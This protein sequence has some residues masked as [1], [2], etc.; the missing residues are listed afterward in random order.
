VRLVGGIHSSSTRCLQRPSRLPSAS[1]LPWCQPPPLPQARQ[2]RL[3]SCDRGKTR[4]LC[5]L[6]QLLYRNLLL[7]CLLTSQLFP[8]LSVQ[9]RDA[10]LLFLYRTDCLSLK[11]PS[12][13]FVP[14]PSGYDPLSS[15]PFPCSPPSTQAV[16]SILRNHD[17]VRYLCQYL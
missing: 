15:A 14:A 2:E 16:L 7:H 1:P 10:F 12:E 8:L 11:S 4:S 9:C 17:L 6:P 5:R 3:G 13:L